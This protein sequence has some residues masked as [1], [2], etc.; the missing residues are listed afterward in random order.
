MSALLAAALWL[1]FATKKG[2]PVS[3]THAI[4]GGLVGSSMLLGYLLTHDADGTLA[5][6]QWDKIGEIA[7]SWVLSPML[8]R[9][10]FLRFVLSSKK[11]RSRL[12]R[13]KSSKRLKEVKAERKAYKEEHRLRFEALPEQER[14]EAA[15]AMARDAQIYGES[16]FDPDELESAYYKGLYV[17]EQRKSSIDAYKAL[18]SWVR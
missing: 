16:D 4:I 18:H 17:I 1:L 6:V 11:A 10:G 5:L 8:G 2:L 9:A 7:I 15:S 13:R 3:T 12:Q 14:L